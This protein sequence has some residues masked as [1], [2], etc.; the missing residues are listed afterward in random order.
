ML[1]ILDLNLPKMTG[2]AILE[3]LG[4]LSEDAFLRIIV[5]SGSEN[6]SD[7]QECLAHG[8]KAFYVK[9]WDIQGY[10]QFVQGSLRNELNLMSVKAA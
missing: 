6:P 5:F 7:K 1:V 10:R 8:A 3:R 9:P 4:K 2:K